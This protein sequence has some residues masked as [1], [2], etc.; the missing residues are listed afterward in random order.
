VLD[1]EDPQ[2][3]AALAPLLLGL[4]G[5]VIGDVVADL[6]GTGTSSSSTCS[7]PSSR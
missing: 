5:S 6:L 1:T 4:V 3:A 2:A 7:A